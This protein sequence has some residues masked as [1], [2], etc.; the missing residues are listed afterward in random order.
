MIDSKF[1]GHF[2]EIL[3]EFLFYF[4]KSILS[5]SLHKYSSKSM[6]VLALAY[7]WAVD[8][9]RSK[10]KY[11][12]TVS[13]FRCSCIPSTSALRRTSIVSV[14]KSTIKYYRS[15]A[16]VLRALFVFGQ[17][18][19]CPVPV[20]VYA[21]TEFTSVKGMR[22]SASGESVTEVTHALLE[23]NEG[24]KRKR[25]AHKCGQVLT[26]FEVCVRSTLFD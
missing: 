1:S 9:Q 12:H 15:R 16:I 7:T 22:H 24:D 26:A 11:V 6:P 25:K 23:L 5:G 13:H 2:Q 8:L 20:L 17:W 3:T 19:N 4:P 14:Q 21:C 18:N 10:M